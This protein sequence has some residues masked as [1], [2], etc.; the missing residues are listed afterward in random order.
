MS[1]FIELEYKYRADEVA[2]GRFKKLMD[3]LAISKFIEASSWDYYYKSPIQ[4]GFLR[5]RDSREKPELTRKL[6]TKDNNNYQRIEW[7]V[8]LDPKKV[9]NTTISGFAETLGFKENFRIFKNCFVYFLDDVNY[10][11]YI[12]YDEHLKEAGRFVE[13]EVN[14]DRV[15]FLN[16][17]DNIFG[18][19]WSAEKTLK[20]A[21]TALESIGITPQNRMKKSLFELFERN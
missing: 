13:V 14:K 4:D 16:S 2:F 21:E 10:V 20:E 3:K 6:K 19:G 11:Y 1:D 12:V 5:F 17:Q 7:D 8:P 15:N 9:T 18:G